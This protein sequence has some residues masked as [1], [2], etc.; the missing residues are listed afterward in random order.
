M[1]KLE[2]NLR[3]HD[4]N[5]VWHSIVCKLLQRVTIDGVVS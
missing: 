5:N 2:A 4:L 3:V 1:A